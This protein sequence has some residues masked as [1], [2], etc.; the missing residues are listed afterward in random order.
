MEFYFAVMLLIYVLI[1][2]LGGEVN[3]KG[4]SMK[5]TNPHK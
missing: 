2:E 1:D 5:G 4:Y 3:Q